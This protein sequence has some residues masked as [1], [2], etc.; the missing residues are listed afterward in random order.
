L[1][2]NLVI[3]LLAGL[4]MIRERRS[5]AGSSRWRKLSGLAFSI[6]TTISTPTT[7][8][9]MPTVTQRLADL[10]GDRF[11][12]SARVIE[13]D[14]LSPQFVTVTLQHDTFRPAGW[15]PGS[16]LQFRPQRGTFST[17]TYTPISWDAAEGTT[18]LIAY[19]H[20]DGPA[21]TWFGA[22]ATGDV[23]E[24]IGP[25][26]SLDLRRPGGRG[27]RVVF[28]GD[29][30]SVALA[31]A[32]R[33]VTPAARHVFEATDPAELTTVLTGLGLAETSAVVPKKDDRAALIGLV[34]E[35]IAQDTTPF[36]LIVT[37]DAATVHAVRRD[38]R[39][40]SRKPLSIKGKAYWAE[41]RAGL[42]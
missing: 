2:G 31:A 14:R 1:D 4:P 41:G 27:G 25:R 9:T 17:R 15:T 24:L 29:E 19:V 5:A 13:A 39:T 42:D 8:T 38:S 22:V 30:S 21:S 23:C 32:L 20:G 12:T 37:G 10:A 28:I 33:T 34:G 16:K 7:G 18:Q 35:A 40:W 11:F 6:S 3:G 26:R 36:D